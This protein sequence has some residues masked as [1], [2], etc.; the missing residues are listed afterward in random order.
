[1]STSIQVGT[2]LAVPGQITYGEFEG[3]PLPTGRTDSLPVII[4][5]GKTEGPVLWITGSIHGNEYS[6]MSTIH[7]LLGVDGRD[8]P[9]DALRGTVIMIPTLNPAGLRTENRSPYYN[10]GSDPNRMFPEPIRPGAET[11]N[12]N[13]PPSALERVY[14]NLFERIEA[15]CDYLIDLHNAVIG[16][17][18]FSFRDPIYYDGPADKKAAR[19][20]LARNDEM[21]QAFGMPIINEFPS[22]EYI[23]KNLHRSVSGSVLNR[24]RKPAF[25]VELGGYLHV[26]TLLRDGA[27]VGLRN[28][29]RW[30]EMLPGE[31]E[32]MPPIPY[33]RVDFPVRRLM[34]PRAHASGIVTHLV[35]AG[36]IIQKGQPVA[37]ITDIYGRPVGPEDGILRTEYE[38]YV[39]GQMQGNVYY[40]NE[41]VLW[42]AV[43]DNSDLLL[44]YPEDY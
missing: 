11:R 43:K 42:L 4:A 15:H 12:E 9:L 10:R 30:A 16:S 27:V 17:I 34:H 22:A 39:V 13:G 29:M 33:P 2:A 5:S 31:R 7:R 23:K 3:V 25:T 8:F 21:M 20:L 24:A 32:P 40:E 1:M 41:S 19:Q 14:E 28:V 18:G 26:D 36:D 38:G 35:D 37:R 6:G 44:P